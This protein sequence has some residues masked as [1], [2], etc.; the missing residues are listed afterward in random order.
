MKKYK[1]SH[2]KYIEH[3]EKK[4]EWNKKYHN[5]KKGLY[6][7]SIADWKRRGKKVFL[8]IEDFYLIREMPCHY[9]G[10]PKASGIDRVENKKDYSKE[11]C[12]PCCSMCNYMKMRYSVEEF[13]NQ[14][15]KIT[16]HS[17]KIL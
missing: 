17:S 5:T 13:I 9:C 4:L 11:N 16:N 7:K 6:A 2:E 1:Y 10:T 14:C 3:R 15:K 12:V 8:S